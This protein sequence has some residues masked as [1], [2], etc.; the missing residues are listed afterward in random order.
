MTDY[1]GE[2][3][4]PWPDCSSAYGVFDLAGFPKDTAA[5]L[6]AWWR[7]DCASV[8]LSPTDWTSPV[9]P[10]GAIDVAAL[11]CAP[12]A[13]LFLNGASLGVRAVPP[14][15]ATVWPR[16]RFAP[17]NLTVVARDAAGAALGAATALTAGAPAALRA[18]VESPFLPPRNGSV[19]A[20]DGA[21]VALV[22][23]EVLDAAGVVC[24]GGAGAV[25]V[26]FTVAGPG[27]VYGVANGD[28]A[29]HSPPKAP[30]RLSFGGR[31]RAIIASAAAG[32]TGDIVVTAAAPGVRPAAVTI[33]AA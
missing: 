25:N 28:P 2:T 22:G 21:D 11:T 29:D 24:A 31:A 16:V 6:S 7:G 3:S 33:V 18:W 23:V 12:Q 30:W 17:G 8:A 9:A 15:A 20:A 5:L 32:A 10:G 26:T 13:E 14:R 4:G 27:R 19:I 1:L